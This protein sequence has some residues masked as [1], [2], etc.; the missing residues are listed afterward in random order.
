MKG[1][2]LMEESITPDNDA[3]RQER[4]IFFFYARRTLVHNHPMKTQFDLHYGDCV[5]GMSRLPNDLVD[6]VVTSPPY[7]LGIN[8]GKYDDG[9]MRDEY[10]AWS[11]TWA[12]E[13]WRVLAEGGSFFLNVGAA[14]ANPLL[15][16]QMILEMTK[17]FVLQNTFHWIKS[18]TIETKKGEQISAGHFKPLN[19][20]RFVT[21]CH[22]YIFHLSKTGNVP[23]D[24]LGIGV[25]YADKSNIK[26]WAHTGG[27]DK[28]CRGNNWFVP[29]QTIRDRKTQRPHPATFPVELAMHCYDLHG[30]KPGLV[31]MDP[32][33]GI[34]HSALAARRCEVSRF[35]G[36]EIDEEYLA[37]AR[38]NLSGD[39]AQ[40]G[41]L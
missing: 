22:E 28:R 14:P 9:Q 6:V 18:I 16:H 25:P 8:Y 34:G 38:L 13:V 12:K 7:N 10:L 5:A 15:P 41:L 36:F 30:R 24:R 31:A 3:Q 19:S 1:V 23:L 39:A 33:L 29:Y 32:F 40:P 11:V 37:E 20:K 4:F 27:G 26:R 2:F 35:I 17:L 21:D